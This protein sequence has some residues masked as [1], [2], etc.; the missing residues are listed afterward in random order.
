MKYG[1]TKKLDT[2]FEEAVEKI[3][4]ELTKEGFG[5]LTEIDVQDA[6]RK[7][8]GVEFDKYLILGACNPSLA[9]KAL[10]AEQEIGLLLPCNVI[11]YEK[12]GETHV[13]A[14]KPKVAM[15]M[16]ENQALEKIAE[17]A[18]KKLQNA[19]EGLM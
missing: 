9:Y 11:V 4:E 7:K 18:D 1:H 5:V 16:V 8:L 2:S 6:F 19:I 17:E 10:Q 13:S 12:E 14:M 15:S 3:R